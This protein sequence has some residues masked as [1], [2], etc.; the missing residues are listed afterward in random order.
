MGYNVTSLQY[1]EV[2]ALNI[3]FPIR[4]RICSLTANAKPCPL[5]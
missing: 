2:F 4:S 3:Y 5:T 1:R